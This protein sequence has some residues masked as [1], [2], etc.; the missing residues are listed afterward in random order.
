MSHALRRA[1]KRSVSEPE[2]D[3]DEAEGESG[4]NEEEAAPDNQSILRLLEENEKVLLLYLFKEPF[5]S[6]ICNSYTVYTLT[7]FTP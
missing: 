6:L 1:V 7:L 3:N 2:G 4:V 5:L